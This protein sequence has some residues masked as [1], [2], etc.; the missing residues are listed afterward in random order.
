MEIQALNE[1]AGDAPAQ[2][3]E[4]SVNNLFRMLVRTLGGS[5]KDNEIIK[6]ISSLSKNN[7][8]RYPP[9]F[10]FPGIEGNSSIFECLCK[11]LE[12]ITFGLNI[13]F[14]NKFDSIETLSEHLSTV[15]SFLG[16]RN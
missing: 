9:V 13:D 1:S 6:K 3:T 11:S 14:T 2:Q 15:S 5:N 8:S 12:Q 10:L 16:T 7:E 4:D